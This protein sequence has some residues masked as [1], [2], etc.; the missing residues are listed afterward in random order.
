MI[1]DELDSG[2]HHKP[3]KIDK[4]KHHSRGFKEDYEDQ[5][6]SRITFKK[7]VQSLKEQSLSDDVDDE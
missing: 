1:Y 3:R 2:S 6:K 5:R 7:Y 4:K